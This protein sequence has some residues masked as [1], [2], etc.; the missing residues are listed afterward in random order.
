MNLGDYGIVT[1]NQKGQSDSDDTN[2]AYFLDCIGIDMDEYGR[3]EVDSVNDSILAIQ[4]D[5]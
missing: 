4:L 1:E 3:Y 5:R 2:V